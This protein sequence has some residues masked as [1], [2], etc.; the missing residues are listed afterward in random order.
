MPIYEYRCNT[1]GDRVEALIHDGVTP[2]CPSC[3]GQDL[4]R[5][6][7]LPAIQTQCGVEPK[8]QDLMDGGAFRMLWNTRWS[9]TV[10]VMMGVLPLI[11]NVRNQAAMN[12]RFSPNRCSSRLR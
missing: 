3:E 10:V 6:L 5:L 8:D 2:V 1:C 7:S 12:R 4:E 11:G 9:R